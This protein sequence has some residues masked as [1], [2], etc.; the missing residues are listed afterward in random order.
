M[1]GHIAQ[2]LALNHP[3]RVCSLG[4]HHTWTRSDARLTSFQAVRKRLAQAGDRES[5]IDISLIGL[6]EPDYYRAHADEMA[7]K[8]AWMLE[9][10]ATLEGWIGQLEACIKGDTYDRLPAIDV[11]TLV[12]CSDRDMI[13][14][15]Y[16][17]RDIHD[18]IA[19]S[20]LESLEG[21]GHVALIERPDAFARI[22][23]DFL[24]RLAP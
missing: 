3:A 16:H 21:S 2:E 12:T 15:P 10:M 18:R 19:A 7:A 14:P 4:L 11:P 13:V 17:G 6:H 8:R 23:F 5:L 22:C 1:G 9:N 24:Q 20:R